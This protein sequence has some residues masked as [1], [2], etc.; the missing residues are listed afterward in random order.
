[1]LEVRRVLAHEGL[2]SQGERLITRLDE[3]RGVLLLT[4]AYGSTPS[5]IA[6]KL[7]AGVENSTAVVAGLNLPMLLRIFNY[8]QSD[9]AGL[10]AIAV[11]GRSERHHA[12]L[13]GRVGR[14]RRAA[15]P[16]ASRPV[17]SS[18]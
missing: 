5:N 13:R 15:P 9:L 3:G 17:R 11:E 4:D 10:S 18:S 2:L 6:N 16:E 7:S 1:M 8:P 12:L 14:L